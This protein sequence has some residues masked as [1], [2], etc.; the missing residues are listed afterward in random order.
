MSNISLSQPAEDSFAFVTILSKL[1]DVQSFLQDLK[2]CLD[3]ACVCVH[4]QSLSRVQLFATLWTVACQVVMASSRESSLPRDWTS[5]SCISS[6]DRRIL[7]PL[8]HMG[9][10]WCCLSLSKWVPLAC[11]GCYAPRRN[12]Q[13]PMAVL[14]E[15]L[16]I[17]HLPLLKAVYAFVIMPAVCVNY[18]IIIIIAH[19]TTAQSCC[20]EDKA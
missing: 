2:P 15:L 14:P 18:K 8:S 1:H 6:I 20:E 5:I 10:P 16:M 4:A 17:S 3:V 13:E 11:P 9:R 7:S 19:N 12:S